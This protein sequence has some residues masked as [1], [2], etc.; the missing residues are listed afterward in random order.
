MEKE[1]KEY[2]E[3]LE[4]WKQAVFNTITTTEKTRKILD[5][6]ADNLSLFFKDLQHFEK[7]MNDLRNKK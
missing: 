3:A 6:A 7:R 4:G 5:M 2:S 1:L